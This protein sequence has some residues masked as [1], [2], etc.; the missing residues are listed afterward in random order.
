MFRLPPVKLWRRLSLVMLFAA[1]VFT[2]AGTCFIHGN[3][4]IH[5]SEGGEPNGFAGKWILWGLLL[6]A[7]LSMFAHTSLSMKRPGSSL[8]SSEMACAFSTGLVMLWT[9][10]DAA[11]VVYHFYPLEM[12]PNAALTA[13]IG[14]FVLFPVIAYIR[15]KRNLYYS[16]SA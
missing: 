11:L 7:F 8:L 16:K 15:E 9:V 14:S 12:V 10:T 2:L 5:W 3:L 4:V 1:A 6:L 13:V